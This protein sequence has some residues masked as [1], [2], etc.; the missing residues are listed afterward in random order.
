MISQD[1]SDR[2]RL[3]I[4]SLLPRLWETDDVAASQAA[5]SLFASPEN[6]ISPH[7][8]EVIQQLTTDFLHVLT[9][10]SPQMPISL[11]NRRDAVIGALKMLLGNLLKYA[12]KPFIEEYVDIALLPVISLESGEFADIICSFLLDY[13]SGVW[14]PHLTKPQLYVIEKSIARSLAALPYDQMDIYWLK[15]QDGMEAESAAM[16]LGLGYLSAAHA[17]E[18][19]VYGLVFLKEHTLRK[20]I[21]L[22]LEEIA[23][24]RCLPAL[25][26]MKQEMSLTDW[27]LTRLIIRVIKV[28]EMVHRDEYQRTLLRASDEK[29]VAADQ[30]LHPVAPIASD[31]FTSARKTLL[32]SEPAPKKKDGSSD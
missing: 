7:R 11:D 27:T 29:Q 14:T 4:C 5:V 25:M 15:M 26:K 13:A 12:S 18:H 3:R 9:S 32:R 1:H 8:T 19:L 30:L 20:D 22:R 24:S 28:I 23:D 6:S 17:V 16:R 2:N 10:F 21:L 31:D